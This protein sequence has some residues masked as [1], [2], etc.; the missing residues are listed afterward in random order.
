MHGRVLQ[1]TSYSPVCHA[2]V[3]N[4][5][6]AHLVRPVIGLLRGLHGFV[7]F[8]DEANVTSLQTVTCS[9]S[10]FT[11]MTPLLPGNYTIPVPLVG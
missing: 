8:V 9:H 6:I 1:L 11:A 7:I 5:A 2:F 4:V 3:G 10:Q